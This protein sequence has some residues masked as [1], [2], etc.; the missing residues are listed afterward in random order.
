MVK[1]AKNNNKAGKKSA[2]E[3]SNKTPKRS[4]ASS[5]YEKVQDRDLNLDSPCTS[6]DRAGQAGHAAQSDDGPS[7][8]FSPRASPPAPGNESDSSYY[9]QV[10][11]RASQGSDASRRAK[12]GQGRRAENDSLS[13]GS[14][15]DSSSSSDSDCKHFSPPPAQATKSQ[16]RSQQPSS[17]GRQDVTNSQ[18][19]SGQALTATSPPV[20][21]S[22]HLSSSSSSRGRSSSKRNNKKRRLPAPLLLHPH[23]ATR[24]ASMLAIKPAPQR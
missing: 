19:L 5:A 8:T 17:R 3:S 21:F 6:P 13:D 18:P 24:T 4:S 11:D 10:F 16:D 9:S 20:N 22:L 15:S 2:N 12:N 14:S 23:L 7:V 1:K